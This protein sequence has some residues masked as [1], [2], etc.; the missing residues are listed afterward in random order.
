MH[1]L[2]KRAGTLGLVAA[3]VLAVSPGTA[4][5][6]G[7]SK[8]CPK[9]PICE[10]ELDVFPGGT[11]S[12]DADAH[13]TGSAIWAVFHGLDHVCS[14]SFAAAAPPQSW[15]CFNVPAGHLRA[16]LNGGDNPLNIGLRW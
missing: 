6:G 2:I 16:T 14:T 7:R 5:A 13:G 4:W 11:L 15:N 8:T 10:F 3:T 1:H 9:E 12:I